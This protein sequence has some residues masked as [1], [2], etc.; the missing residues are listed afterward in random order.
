MVALILLAFKIQFVFVSYAFEL[1]SEGQSSGEV[2]VIFQAMVMSIIVVVLNSL[3][4]LV[5][6]I[7]SNLNVDTVFRQ[8]EKALFSEQTPVFILR[9]LFSVLHHQLMFYDLYRAWRK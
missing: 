7:E 8:I 6:L 2:I 1:K 5:V 4:R 3:L 9:I